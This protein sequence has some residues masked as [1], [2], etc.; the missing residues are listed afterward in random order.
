MQKGIQHV[1]EYIHRSTE[2]SSIVCFLLLTIVYIDDDW[3]SFIY[4]FN[5]ELIFKNMIDDF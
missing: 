1:V 2:S 3:L 4:A 5:H